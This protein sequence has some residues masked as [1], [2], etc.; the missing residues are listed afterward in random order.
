MIINRGDDIIT[1]HITNNQTWL[2][3]YLATKFQN[4]V[5]SQTTHIF[6]HALKDI[7]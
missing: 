5:K 1:K 7:C 4:S 6:F 2:A 3:L